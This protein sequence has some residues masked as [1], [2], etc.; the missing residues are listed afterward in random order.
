[1]HPLQQALPS[2]VAEL[3][4]AAPLSPGKVAFAWKAVVGTAVERAT[5]V[6]LEHGVLV[7]EPASRQ[8]ARELNRS[9]DVILARLQRL[10][11][12]DAVKSIVVRSKHA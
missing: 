5:E 12:A 1:M 3:L 9:R 11:G 4:A 10:L 2:V 8:W 6:R 7:I